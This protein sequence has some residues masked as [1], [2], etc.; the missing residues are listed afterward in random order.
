MI[1]GFCV[2]ITHLAPGPDGKDG[3]AVIEKATE[4]IH[5]CLVPVG[6]QFRSPLI[7]VLDPAAD[8]SPKPRKAAAESAFSR[9]EADP[10]PAGEEALKDGTLR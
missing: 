5:N 6:R 2:D 3:H 1:D 4:G 7:L 8:R 10:G 9:G